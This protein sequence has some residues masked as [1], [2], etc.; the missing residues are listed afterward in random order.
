MGVECAA[1]GGGFR[2][3]STGVR[4]LS[5]AAQARVVGRHPACRHHGPVRLRAG[6]CPWSRNGVRCAARGC[7]PHAGPLRFRPPLQSGH[8]GTVPQGADGTADTGAGC[9]GHSGAK[10]AARHRPA[11]SGRRQRRALARNA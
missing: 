8:P 1:A 5:R 9:H 2:L 3:L 4:R 10:P 11:G 6:L 7:R